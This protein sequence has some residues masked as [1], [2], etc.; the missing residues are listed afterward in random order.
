MAFTASNAF[1]NLTVT[2]VNPTTVKVEF[3]LPIADTDYQNDSRVLF[4]ALMDRLN[5]AINAINPRPASVLVNKAINVVNQGSNSQ[6]RDIFTVTV[7]RQAV[8]GSF[9]VDP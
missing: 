6:V 4:P 5:T 2:S 3:E 9:V 1:T 8:P 7:V